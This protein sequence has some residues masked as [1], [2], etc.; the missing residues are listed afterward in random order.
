MAT[1]LRELGIEVIKIFGQ[2]SYAGSTR[3]LLD[4]KKFILLA[5]NSRYQEGKPIKFIRRIISADIA[6]LMGADVDSA[7]RALIVN[8][9]P[10]INAGTNTLAFGVY[11]YES[12]TFII[13]NPKAIC[14]CDATS[15]VS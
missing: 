4:T 15:A 3:T 12:V 13:P 7:Q 10:I 2:Y 8:P 11:G 6:N 14:F 9:T 1:K 5:K